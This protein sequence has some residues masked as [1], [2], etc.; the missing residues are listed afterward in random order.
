[1][2]SDSS[3]D[4]FKGYTMIGYDPETEKQM[5]RFYNSLSEKDK[6]R[7]AA[8]EALRLRHGGKK[9]ICNLFNCDIKTLMQGIDDLNNDDAM[10]L[11]RIR[12]K[13]GGR[14]SVLTKK[15]EIN[16]AFLHT[17]RE[18][19]AGSPMNEKIRWTNLTRPQLAG[20]LAG[21]GYKVSVPVITQLLKKHGFRK[22]KALKSVRGGETAHRNEQFL[23]ISRLCAEYHK[24]GMPVLSMDVKKKE[25]IGNFFRDGHLYT[26]DQLR[27]NDHD[28]KSLADGI[29]IP[30]GLYDQKNNIGYVTIGTSHDTAEFACDCIRH[31]RQNHGKF[32]YPGKNSM[33]LTC[34]SGGSNNARHY[35]FKE[36][37]QLSADDLNLEIR[38]AHY[39][40]Y[41]SKYNPIEHRLFPHVTRACKGLIFRSIEI[42]KEA[43]GNAKTKTG[44]KTISSVLEKTYDTGKKVSSDFKK[45]MKIIFDDFLPQ[46]NYRAVPLQ[47]Q[48]REVI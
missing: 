13:G 22:R 12:R 47:S 6:R 17:V 19:T 40:P 35:L 16:E 1:M 41:T 24:A 39:P 11:N 25:L 33:L 4:S 30:H 26:Q 38:I 31:Y 5:Q 9:Y 36:Q 29:A 32:L 45:N 28:F 20:L 37:I 7:Y 42:V 14:K 15:T 48:K 27:V 23:N 2:L 18:R 3:T 46:W 34:D 21:K 10:K 8:V 43:M 44:L